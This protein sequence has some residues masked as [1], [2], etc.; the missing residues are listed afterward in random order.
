MLY[1]SIDK[2]L[3]IVDS[4]YM[5]VHVASRRA[6]QMLDNNHYQMNE[7]DYVNKKPLGKALE[8]VE[9]GLIQIQVG[10]E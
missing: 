7:R 10:K 5:L 2:L 3:N 9:K 4:K 8:E 1:P 6:K